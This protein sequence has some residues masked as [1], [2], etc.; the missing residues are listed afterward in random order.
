M[1]AFFLII[2]SV[3]LINNKTTMT[4]SLGY[5]TFN[6]IL[7]YIPLILLNFF[8]NKSIFIL[9][10]IH[11]FLTKNTQIQPLSSILHPKLFSSQFKSQY[12]QN[13]NKS[14]IFPFFPFLIIHNS[15]PFPRFLSF[16]IYLPILHPLPIFSSPSSHHEPFSYRQSQLLLFPLMQ[17]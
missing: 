10:L 3:L 1:Y 7:F 12:Q 16:N 4:F 14:Q 17:Q 5:G 6:Q 9:F 11:L 2:C 13:N 15:F 8:I